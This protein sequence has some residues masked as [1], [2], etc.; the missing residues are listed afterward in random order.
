MHTKANLPSDDAQSAFNSTGKMIKRQKTRAVL[1]K[2]AT[3]RMTIPKKQDEDTFSQLTDL[4]SQ[5]SFRRR[6]ATQ[7]K[8]K[9]TNSIDSHEVSNKP[10]KLPQSTI[11]SQSKLNSEPGHEDQI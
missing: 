1:S 11:N 6:R 2:Q 7:R 3:K 5:K 4:K 10:P 8:E 9:S